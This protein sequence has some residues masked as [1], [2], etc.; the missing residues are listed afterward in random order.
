LTAAV[1]TSGDQAA[2]LRGKLRLAGVT[3]DAPLDELCDVLTVLQVEGVPGE[4]LKRWRGHLDR[5]TW[6]I[7]P[8]DREQW[9]LSP[10]EQASMARL[11]ASAG[12]G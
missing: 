6:K 12:G 8:P 10:E 3:D 4:E 7:R 2:Y 11:A 9:G 1:L 5:A